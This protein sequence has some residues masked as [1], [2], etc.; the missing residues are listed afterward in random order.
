M[1]VISLTVWGDLAHFRKHFATTSPMTYAFP[2]PSAIRG[3]IGAILGFN[4][5]E[6]TEK[7]HYSNTFI[8][9]RILSKIKKIRLGINLLN[10][11]GGSWIKV[12]MKPAADTHTQ[13]SIEF[14]KNPKFEIFFHHENQEIMDTLHERLTKGET[15]FTPYLGISECLANIDINWDKD[16]SNY[17]GKSRV[18]SVIPANNIQEFLADNLRDIQ[19]FKETV[20]V[21]INS[22]RIREHSATVIFPT[23]NVPL[24]VI[25]SETFLYPNP[26]EFLEQ[27][28]LP[29]TFCFIK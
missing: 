25:A 11:K 2:P 21:F 16:I 7:L 24:P 15:V 8:G 4:K 23:E 26:N 14:L 10:S 27:Q 3:L 22:D 20:P 6:Y 18:I 1:R 5:N 28:K 19:V 13:I 29:E 9:V 17:V 12:F